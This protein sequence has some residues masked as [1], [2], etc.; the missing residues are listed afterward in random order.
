MKKLLAILTLFAVAS[1]FTA[2]T[3]Y[4]VTSSGMSFTP[5][6]LSINVGDTVVWNNVSGTHNV[7]G[8]TST[9]P[10]NPMSFGNGAAS[11]SNWTYFFVFTTAGTYNYQCDVHASS[12]MTGVITVSAA[13][14][15]KENDWAEA[16]TVYPNPFTDKLTITLGDNVLENI[17][18][19]EFYVYDVIGNQVMKIQQINSN[20]ITLKT[21]DF[22]NGIY[23]YSFTSKG[24]VLKTGK[25]VK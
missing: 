2:Q 18:E 1:S 8:S 20:V 25:L 7:N 5:A 9:F 10:N 14:A 24:E 19:V 21:D 11:S 3:S 6:T 4:T 23:I 16:L 22:S 15:I 17:N 13:N 12:G